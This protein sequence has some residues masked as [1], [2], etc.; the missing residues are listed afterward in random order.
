V[1]LTAHRGDA[2]VAEMPIWAGG[3]GGDADIRCGEYVR[4]S[5]IHPPPTRTPRDVTR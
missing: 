3:E 2:P 1:A 5:G 4:V